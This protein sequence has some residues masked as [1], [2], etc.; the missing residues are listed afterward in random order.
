MKKAA[1]VFIILF[2]VFN[3]IIS[4]TNL[5]T[6][7]AVEGI[8]TEGGFNT[9]DNTGQ[10]Q[11]TLGG[12]DRTVKATST[13]SSVAATSSNIS[14]IAM[15]LPAIVS[16]IMTA[17][18]RPEYIDR[19]SDIKQSEVDIFKAI[20]KTE[21]ENIDTE[22]LESIFRKF[23]ILGM[24]LGYY[25]IFDIY[26]F[27]EV[28]DDLGIDKT[29]NDILKENISAVYYNMQLIALVISALA[30]IYI[31]IRMAISTTSN[32]KARY[33]KL[34]KSWFIGCVLIFLLH[35]IVI[36]VMDMSKIIQIVIT[37]V[38]TN[39]R[40]DTDFEYNIVNRIGTN[41]TN[42]IGFAGISSVIIYWMMIYYQLKFFLM[43]I[44]RKFEIAFLIIIAPLI[45]VTYSIDK[46][47]DGRS[48]VF[49]AW[50]RELISEVFLQNLHSI[51]YL[52]FIVSAGNIAVKSPLLAIIFFSALSRVEKVV[53]NVF[54]IQGRGIRDIKIPFLNK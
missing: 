29:F 47:A 11:A 14:N 33:K 28:P 9:W 16:T 48:Q 21:P 26:F 34:L 19:F 25:E 36:F 38:A 22:W 49:N 45:T 41:Y 15:A 43:Y 20:I 12:V 6:V 46:S 44:Y 54:K 37:K 23:T 10:T 31:G 27:D 35:F 39:I 2:I 17:V 18:V 50:C 24:V 52:L 4:T 3:L 53:K 13:Q 5:N 7:V 30:L 1:K 8:L 42:A 51:A 32:D 40:I